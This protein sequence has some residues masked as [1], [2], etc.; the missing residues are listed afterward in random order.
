MERHAPVVFPKLS[1]AN[2]IHRAAA[3]EDD[4]PIQMMIRRVGGRPKTCTFPSDSR[5]TCKGLLNFLSS[6]VLSRGMSFPLVFLSLS[7]CLDGQEGFGGDSKKSLSD[8]VIVS[9]A[10]DGM[11][12]SD[13]AEC[14]ASALFKCLPPAKWG[15]PP[16]CQ[17][18]IFRNEHLA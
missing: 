7:F 1:C 15:P 9:G 3:Q 6:H 12:L 14:E 13:S 16:S 5:T 4:A 17:H 18:D 10:T 2:S 8:T 11:L